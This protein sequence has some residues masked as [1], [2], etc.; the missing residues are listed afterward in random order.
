MVLSEGS[1]SG[2][3]VVQLAPPQPADIDHLA[4]AAVLGQR[5]LFPHHYGVLDHEPLDLA[6]QPEGL[7]LGAEGGLEGRGFRR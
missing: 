6:A 4:A 3:V 1:F 5:L 7:L 2:L